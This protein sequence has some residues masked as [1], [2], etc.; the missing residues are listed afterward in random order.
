MNAP[1]VV[2][3]II[4]RLARTLKDLTH[5]VA[6]V[7]A[8]LG[9]DSIVKIMT[10]VVEKICAVDPHLAIIPRARILVPAMWDTLEMGLIVE[11]LALLQQC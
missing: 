8:L 2:H 6:V 7:P 5:V 3:V 4:L 1:Q 9:M 11:V 10:N